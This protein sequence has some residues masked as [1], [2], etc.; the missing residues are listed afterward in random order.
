MKT[1]FTR[2]YVD[3]EIETKCDE[4]IEYYKSNQNIHL[5]KKRQ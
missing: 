3:K 2:K 4:I 1:I 5:D